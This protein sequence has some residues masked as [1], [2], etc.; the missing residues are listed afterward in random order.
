MVKQKNQKDNDD[1]AIPD[2]EPLPS[3]NYTYL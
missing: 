3:V 1:R 2:K